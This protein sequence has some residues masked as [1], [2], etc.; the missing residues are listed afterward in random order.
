MPAKKKAQ[1][2][3]QSLDAV[4]SLPKLLCCL[5][6]HKTV[7]FNCNTKRGQTSRLTQNS[8]FKPAT[9]ADPRNKKKIVF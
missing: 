2:K 1:I 9:K 4:C 5:L 3:A 6:Q 8:Q 7:L